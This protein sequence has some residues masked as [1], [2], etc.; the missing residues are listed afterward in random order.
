[1][2]TARNSQDSALNSLESAATSARG[3]FACAFSSSDEYERALISERRAQG[4]YDRPRT[5][6]PMIAF[7]ACSLMMAGF[8][9]AFS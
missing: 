1:M 8:V 3:G 7:I 6:W 4:R 9:V 2:D 5:N